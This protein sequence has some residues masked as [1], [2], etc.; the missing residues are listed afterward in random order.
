MRILWLVLEDLGTFLLSN[1]RASHT[2]LESISRAALKAPA[3]PVLLPAEEKREVEPAEIADEAT[4]ADDVG[5]PV[6]T[7]RTIRDILPNLE[8]VSE[9]SEPAIIRRNMVVGRSQEPLY[10]RPV[11]E[12]DGVLT[13]L[14]YGATVSA[15]ATTQQWVDVQHKET[16][17]YIHRDALYESV[18]QTRP[19]FVVKEFAGPSSTNTQ[20][21]RSIIE[22][23]FAAVALE[24][25]LQAEEYV[26]YRL[27][28]VGVV[29]PRVE[30]RPRMA[31]SWQ[32]IYRGLS[33]VRIGVRPKTNAVMEYADAQG[34]GHLAYVE[35][36]FPDESITVSEIGSPEPGYFNERTLDK[37]AWQELQAIFIQFS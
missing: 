23:E 16:V 4:L 8:T 14:P 22:D 32:R 18:L 34:V 10:V 11:R 29:P 3:P 27:L 33:G 28:T 36:V 19:Y 5:E 9:V 1:F 35:A 26:Y 30:T 31:G 17:G 20:R 15:G 6:Q 12:Y 24:L 21:L 13:K 2:Q 7:F 37:T 25:P